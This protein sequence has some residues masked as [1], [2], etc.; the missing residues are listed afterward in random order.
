M[1]K[2]NL[3]NILVLFLALVFVVG[4]SAFAV[5]KTLRVGGIMDTTG[6]T[7]DVGK[8]YALGMDEAFKYIN[9][10]G[11]VNGKKIKTSMPMA[12]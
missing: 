6:A 9:A 10:H 4:F 2:R 3:R 11:G 5:A 12:G 7:S 1:E 8:D